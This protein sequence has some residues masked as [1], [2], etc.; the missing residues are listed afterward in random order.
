MGV[1]EG[2]AAIVFAERR[3]VQL[4]EKV[5][6]VDAQIQLGTLAPEEGHGRGFGKTGIK[7]LVAWSAEGIAMQEWRASSATVKIGKANVSRTKGLAG[8]R[9]DATA[10]LCDNPGE[11]AVIGLEC[12]GAEVILCAAEVRGYES[13][14]Q[15]SGGRG[16]WG[17][18]ALNWRPR[19][20]SVKLIGPAHV[21]STKGFSNEIVATLKDR[22]IIEPG[23]EHVV[24][25]D[26]IG[27]AIVP[28]LAR[29]IKGISCLAG[30]LPRATVKTTAELVLTGK[31]EAVGIV[32]GCAYI[33]G[34]EVCV[35]VSAQQIGWVQD[36]SV[37]INS[38]QA[39]DSLQFAGRAALIPEIKNEATG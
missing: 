23:K 16:G 22:Q 36:A 34:V 11:L 10:G 32:P 24:R 18:V 13:R 28:F 7:G 14:A 6:E 27:R 17:V 33:E 21:P 38:V 26:K 39:D 3:Q 8:S 30:P 5:E 15:G 12:V 29:R 25:H 31:L 20:A 37:G 19:E 2:G 1:V 4:V 9:A 35:N